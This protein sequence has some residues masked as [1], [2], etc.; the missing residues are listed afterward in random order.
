MKRRIILASASPRRINMLRIAGYELTVVPA[1]IDE[2]KFIL[3][4]PIA[5]VS[6]LAFEK[7]LSAKESLLSS[8]RNVL[9]QNECIIAADTIVYFDEIIGKPEDKEDALKILMKLSGQMH[10]VYTGVAILST[11]EDKHKVFTDE[12][13]VYFKTYSPEELEEYLNSP[14]PYDKAGAY[15][16]QGYFGKYIH[17]IEG[18]YDNV[19]GLPL[20]KLLEE[21]QNF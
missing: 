21:L 8:Q 17:H 15:A 19:M 12:T 10:K 20:S 9:N 1:E 18:D 11:R 3:D 16:I 4:D 7:A 14:E 5:T 6:K 13:S 2:S